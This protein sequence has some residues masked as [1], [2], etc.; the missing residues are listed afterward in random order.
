MIGCEGDRATD[1]D[2]DIQNRPISVASNEDLGIM[3][4]NPNTIDKIL[5]QLKSKRINVQQSHPVLRTVHEL[6]FIEVDVI[7]AQIDVERNIHFWNSPLVPT[8][9]F[10]TDNNREAVL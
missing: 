3:P 10:A 9:T 2:S 6:G 5:M 4:S 8:T 1:H 7:V